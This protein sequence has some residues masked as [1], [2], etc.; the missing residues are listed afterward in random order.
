MELNKLSIYNNN[1]KK[2]KIEHLQ[3]IRNFDFT[4]LLH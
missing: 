2:N 4:D 1:L 3:N